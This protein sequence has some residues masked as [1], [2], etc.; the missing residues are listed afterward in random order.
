LFCISVSFFFLRIFISWV[1]APLISSNFNLNLFISL[2]M[3]FSVSFWCLF[4]AS[5]ISFICFSHILVFCCL[6]ISWMPPVHFGRPCLE[7]SLW[8]SH[9]L[10][11]GFLLSECSCGL[12]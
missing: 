5:M 7:S 8:N 1:T 2:F 3:V 12:W 11:A 6:W 10:L 9:W 4:R